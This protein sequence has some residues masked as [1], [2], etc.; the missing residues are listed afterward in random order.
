MYVYIRDLS[1]RGNPVW[2]YKAEPESDALFVKKEVEKF[3]GQR[4]S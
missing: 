3:G 2:F 4:I 1:R